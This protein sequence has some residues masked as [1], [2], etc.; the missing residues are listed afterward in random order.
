MLLFECSKNELG[1]QA[2]I[3]FYTRLRSL[4]FTPT[5]FVNQSTTD[6]ERL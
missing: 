4:F 3:D 6:I 2:E 5:N 1:T